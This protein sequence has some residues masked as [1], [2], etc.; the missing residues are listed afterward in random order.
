MA[1]DPGVAQRRI[2]IPSKGK[3][4]LIHK[5][6]VEHTKLDEKMEIVN[7]Q[8]RDVLEYVRSYPNQTGEMIN[9]NNVKGVR[10]IALIQQ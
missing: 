5:L 7:G 6:G 3:H 2:L 10:P 8:T 1:F 9:Q 4:R